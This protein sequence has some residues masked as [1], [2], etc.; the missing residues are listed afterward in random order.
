MGQILGLLCEMVGG[1]RFGP[2]VPFAIPESPYADFERAKCQW[3]RQGYVRS[4]PIDLA[5]WGLGR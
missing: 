2:W 3:C 5:K 1:H 4:R